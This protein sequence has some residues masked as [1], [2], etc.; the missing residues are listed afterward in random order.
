MTPD[1]GQ[2]GNLPPIG[3]RPIAGSGMSSETSVRR[4]T[5]GGRLPTCP[6]TA[7]VIPNWNGSAR[8]ANLLE[9]LQRQTHPIDRVIVGDNGSTDESLAVAKHSGVT[10]LEL[11][12]NTGFRHSVNPRSQ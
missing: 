1:V 3:N 8:L 4:F 11:P 10:L 12:S 7:I 9:R 6:T 5:I 2:V